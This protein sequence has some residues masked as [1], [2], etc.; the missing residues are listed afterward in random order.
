ME[1]DAPETHSGT[2]EE[3]KDI[4]ETR[5]DLKTELVKSLILKYNL[6]RVNLEDINV[7]KGKPIPIH[8]NSNKSTNPYLLNEVL[9]VY[10][11]Y[12]SFFKL[13]AKCESFKT[14][15]KACDVLCKYGHKPNIEE[16]R[17]VSSKVN[18]LNSC[19]RSLSRIVQFVTN[20]IEFTKLLIPKKDFESL[21][22]RCRHVSRIELS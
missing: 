9:R 1:D 18:T 20:I 12:P 4:A 5:F 15:R 21:M 3:S 2:K 10:N 6:D 7:D 22:F 8:Y 19:S 16:L 11:I 14:L 13:V 17:L